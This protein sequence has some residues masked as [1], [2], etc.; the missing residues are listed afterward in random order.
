MMLIQIEI[1]ERNPGRVDVDCRMLESSWRKPTEN[2]SAA[3]DA[4]ADVLRRD[5]VA[6]SK[7]FGT[8][9][10][11]RDEAAEQIRREGLS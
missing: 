7:T 4:I 11:F 9:E 3:C 2:E 6:V 1:D 8:V 5:V 10:T